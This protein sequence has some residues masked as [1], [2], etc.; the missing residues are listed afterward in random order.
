MVAFDVIF[1]I[2]C[3]N[4]FCCLG[5]IGPK[6]MQLVVV[7]AVSAA[8]MAATMAFSMASTMFIFFMSFFVFV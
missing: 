2:K 3:Y 8:V 6:P 5:Q 7:M 1:S 4:F